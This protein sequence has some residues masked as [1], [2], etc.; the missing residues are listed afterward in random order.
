MSGETGP[1]TDRHAEWIARQ[2]RH[3]VV[4]SLVR[5]GSAAEI[6][7]SP[8]VRIARSGPT[9]APPVAPAAEV[10]AGAI[11]AACGARLGAVLVEPNV[12]LTLGGYRGQTE[13]WM[14]HPCRG[15]LALIARADRAA[16]RFGVRL[17]GEALR[18]AR[19]RA[20]MMIN[21]ES[22]A[23]YAY[24]S[25]Q[26]TMPGVTAFDPTGGW[27]GLGLWKRTLRSRLGRAQAAG[28]ISRVVEIDHVWAGVLKGYPDAAILRYLEADAIEVDEVTTV[29]SDLPLARAYECGEP[30]YDYPPALA[31]DPVIQAHRRLWNDALIDFYA[32]PWHLMIRD[33]PAFRRARRTIYD[34]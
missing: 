23:G 2:E 28:E 19:R 29:D 20:V 32:G 34:V 33:D 11:Y 18:A 15:D 14:T 21:V 22:L 1:S 6:R 7:S 27:R 12:V 9:V 10:V 26:S 24:T 25:A 31:D 13:C 17:E 5:T 4:Q 3:R 16:R 8:L 30:N